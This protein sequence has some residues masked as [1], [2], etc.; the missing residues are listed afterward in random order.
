MVAFDNDRLVAF[1]KRDA[2]PNSFH[3]PDNSPGR[4]L[5]SE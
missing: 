1:G 2:I 4:L 5:Y 3:I